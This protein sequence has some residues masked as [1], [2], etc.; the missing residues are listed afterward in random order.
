V[1]LPIGRDDR[2]S[3]VGHL[4]EPRSRLIVCL[5]ALLV[6]FGVCFWQNH[7]L[8]SVLDR[9]LPPVSSVSGQHGLAAVQNQS[10][11][12]R[13]GLQKIERGASALASS[14]H[15]RGE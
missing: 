14:P 9:A 7:A 1:F 6:A 2:L 3:I 11:S 10:A 5:T 4:D 12:E 15:H 13:A 8:L